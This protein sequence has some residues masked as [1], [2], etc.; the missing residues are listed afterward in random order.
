MTYLKF[1][2]SFRQYLQLGYITTKVLLY[3]ELSAYHI[4]SLQVPDEDY[5]L[6]DLICQGDY[7]HPFSMASKMIGRTLSLV[8]GLRGRV[9]VKPL[10]LLTSQTRL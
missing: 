4:G 6:F 3:K 2:L 9:L 7:K 5:R 1:G 10:G 8:E